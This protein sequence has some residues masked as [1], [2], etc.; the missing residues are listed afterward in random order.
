MS[1]VKKKKPVNEARA[2]VIRLDQYK[3][4]ISELKEEGKN[5]Y[6]PKIGRE[7]KQI[8]KRIKKIA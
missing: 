8:E 5:H 2:N 1:K 6:R 4:K 3:Q 7:I